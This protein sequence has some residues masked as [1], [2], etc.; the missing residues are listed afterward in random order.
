[1]SLNLR[2]N[3]MIWEMD[4][5]VLVKDLIQVMLARIQEEQQLANQYVGTGFLFCKKHAMMDL[6]I[7]LDV[8]KIASE[9]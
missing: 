6:K 8:T 4:V 5:M 3:V 2:K 7:T 9:T 1:M